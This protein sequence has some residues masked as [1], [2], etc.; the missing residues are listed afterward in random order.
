MVRIN[1]RDIVSRSVTLRRHEPR[2]TLQWNLYHQCLP[3][4]VD[5]WCELSSAGSLAMFEHLRYNMVRD[6]CMLKYWIDHRPNILMYISGN[7]DEEGTYEYPN[8][9][10]YNH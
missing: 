4:A 3:G 8:H 1:V 7:F 9:R 2:P 10:G 6:Q 5:T